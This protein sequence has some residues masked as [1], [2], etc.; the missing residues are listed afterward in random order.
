MKNLI[1][2]VKHD[3]AFYA[4]AFCLGLGIIGVVGYVV[5]T[6]FAG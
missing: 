3:F 4:L 2:K 5:Y 1:E 6:F